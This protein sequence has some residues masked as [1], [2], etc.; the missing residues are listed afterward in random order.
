[1]QSS[2]DLDIFVKNQKGEIEKKKLRDILI[3]LSADE[4]QRSH[5]SEAAPLTVDQRGPNCSVYALQGAADWLVSN[6][7]TYPRARKDK[8][9][10]ESWRQYAKEEKITTVGGVELKDFYSFVKKR[11]NKVKLERYQVDE[12]K[13]LEENIKKYTKLLCQTIAHYSVI[14]PFS[15]S[16]KI[17]YL[18]TEEKQRQAFPCIDATDSNGH[19]ALAWAY[20]YYEHEYYVLM[21]HLGGH[22]LCSMRDIYISNTFLSDVF[23]KTEIMYKI[24]SNW[25]SKEEFVNIYQINLILHKMLP[26]IIAREA[27][28]SQYEGNA[29]TNKFSMLAIPSPA[30]KTI[31]SPH[32][33]MDCLV[34]ACMIKDEDRIRKII[35]I[36]GMIIEKKTL[37]ESIWERCAEPNTLMEILKNLGF[38]F[39]PSD[40]SPY[41]KILKAI[42]LAKPVSLELLK[43]IDPS[44]L[45][46]KLR[47]LFCYYIEM[48]LAQPK[49]FEYL[50]LSNP[51]LVWQMALYEKNTAL[52]EQLLF[53][54]TD[55]R[56]Y[57]DVY[58]D[59]LKR[60]INN[61]LTINANLI[62][63]AM[64]LN[65]KLALLALKDF[66]L[67]ADK[68]K[69]DTLLDSE[70]KTEYKKTAENFPWIELYKSIVFTIRPE[71]GWFDLFYSRKDTENKVIFQSL[72]KEFPN[73]LVLANRI[74]EYRKL[75]TLRSCLVKV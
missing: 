26:P 45:N 22:Y 61:P 30:Y 6:T 67:T 10:Q 13:E 7:S 20:I 63:S 64:D 73:P 27:L 43:M 17:S 3:T 39:E 34:H 23:P 55:D 44:V 37:L 56:G 1:M 48:K 4:I 11:I 60:Y 8:H 41:V 57:V 33:I 16:G 36:P 31:F 52:C 47:Y 29:S 70:S 18:S 32:I 65:C 38:I 15:L 49:I 59:V 25:E 35:N 51:D 54:Y 5:V 21:T 14:L 2:I 40:E 9:Y 74:D 68:K 62:Q 42:R 28:P 12:K 50:V 69:I 58:Q 46:K 72:T 53:F 19:V 24:G 71:R 75:R 66:A